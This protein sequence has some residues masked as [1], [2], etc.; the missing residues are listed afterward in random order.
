ML[1]HN[2]YFNT[3]NVINQHYWKGQFLSQ[4]YH[5]NT[6]NVINQLVNFKNLLIL[7]IHFNTSNVINQPNLGQAGNGLKTN[8]NTSNVI[9]QLFTVS[10]WQL[11]LMYFNTSNVINQLC[12]LF[13]KKSF[14]TISI[15]QMLLINNY[16]DYTYA[17]GKTFQYIK[18]Y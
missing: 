2:R 5:F 9:N 17:N 3:S 11:I 8:F 16:N 1:L 4:T 13:S 12:F 7:I 10:I 14:I 18:C 15:H 6:S